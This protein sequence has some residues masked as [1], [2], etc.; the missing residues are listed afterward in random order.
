MRICRITTSKENRIEESRVE[1]SLPDMMSLAIRR[2][3]DGVHIV[4]RLRFCS[5]SII[6]QRAPDLLGNHYLLARL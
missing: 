2:T 4:V 1:A 3:D 5:D 6:A